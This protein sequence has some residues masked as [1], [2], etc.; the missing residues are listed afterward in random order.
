MRY[1]GTSYFTLLFT[2]R[3]DL[4][5]NWRAHLCDIVR[6][7]DELRALSRYGVRLLSVHCT[8]QIASGK[9]SQVLHSIHGI[10]PCV[11]NEFIYLFKRFTVAHIDKAQLIAVYM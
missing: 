4:L 9:H 1:I 3:V 10:K 5:V 7:R 6:A 11:T 8:F 2:L